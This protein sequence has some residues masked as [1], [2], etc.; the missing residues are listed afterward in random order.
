MSVLA[1]LALVAAPRFED[2]TAASG[3]PAVIGASPASIF[4]GS[5]AWV[6][7]DGDPFPDLLLG[8]PAGPTRLY[9]NSG[10]LPFREATPAALTALPN[11]SCIT[12]FQWNDGPLG[13]RRALALVQSRS[14][15]ALGADP[16]AFESGG[17]FIVPFPGGSE[18]A[19]G[20]PATSAELLT[21]G[22]LDGDGATD[23]FVA[24]AGCGTGT[25]AVRTLFRLERGALGYRLSPEDAVAS[26]GCNPVPMVTDFDGEGRPALLVATD[27]GS[28]E[29][30][31]FLYRAG[32]GAEALPGIYG[33]GVAAAD[34]DGDAAL[35]YVLS[36]IGPDLVIRSGNGARSFGALGRATEWGEVGRR[37]KWGIAFL[38][39]DNDGDEELW[40]TAGLPGLATG[41]PD[42]VDDD[43]HLFVPEPN[44][45][46]TL[47]VD[48][49]DQADAAGLLELTAKRAV[50]VADFD[51]DGRLDALVTGLDARSLYR[52]VTEAAGRWVAFRAPELPG[53]NFRLEACGRVQYREL[54]GQQAVAAHERVVHFGLGDCAG[55]V[56]LTVR[57][58]WLGQDA[59]RTFDAVDQ[60]FALEHPGAV[61]F[62]PPET[63]PGATVRVYSTL[64]GETVVGGVGAGAS[65]ADF[66]APS[67]AGAH[68]FLVVSAGHTLALQPKLTVRERVDVLLTDPHPVR[69]GARFRV[70]AGD[71]STELQTAGAAPVRV[72][73]GGV[74]QEVPS[75]ANFGGDSRA[76]VSPGIK[77][78]STVR[79]APLDA[80]GAASAD[81]EGRLSV[82]VGDAVAPLEPGVAPWRVA[83]LLAFDEVASVQHG[84]QT[85][86]EVQH[87]GRPG[88]A[89]PSRSR[90]WVVTPIARADGQD[91][92]DVV[93]IW[94]DADGQLVEPST[95]EL[96][97]APGCTLVSAAWTRLDIGFDLVGWSARLRAGTAPGAF[98]VTAGGLTGVV[99]LMPREPAAPTALST[100]ERTPTGLRLIPRDAFGQR[101]GSGVETVPPF[102]YS[103][104]GA[105]RRATL[106]GPLQLGDLVGT[107][108]GDTMHWTRLDSA[109][110]TTCT[111]RGRG[112]TGALWLL[113]GAVGLLLRRRR[114]GPRAVLALAV[115]GCAGEAP[116]PQRS[117]EVRSGALNA[118]CTAEVIGKGVKQV[119]GDYL[120][121]VIQCE[122]GSAPLEALKAQ[123]VAARSYLYYKLNTSGSI[124][125]GQSDQVYSCG[126]TPSATHHQA[127][128]ETAG[129]VLRYSNTQVAAF[130]VA[131]AVPSTG[132][133]VAAPGDND[134][135]NT[136]K[137]VTYNW[138][139]SGSGLEQ[140]TLG[141]V[142]AGNY[143]NRGCKSQNGASC[144]AKAGWGYQDILRFYYG[145][146]IGI[147]TAT[148]SCV[149]ACE[150]SGGAT[151]STPCGNCGNMTRT[152]DGCQWGAWSGCQG[153]GPCA[154]GASE[155][156]GCGS[157]GSQT[158]SCTGE[159]NWGEFGACSD[160]G[161]CAPGATETEACGWCG[162]RTRSCDGG[163]G[164][165]P[166]G[167]CGG[168]G[169]C[170]AGAVEHQ[171]CA[172]CGVE[173]RS[174]SDQCTWS[175]YGS[176]T[177]VDPNDGGAPVACMTDAPGACGTGVLMCLSGEVACV[178]TGEAGDETCNDIDD[179]CDG[180]TDE[181]GA[182]LGATLPPRA[183]EFVELD[184]PL[185]ASPG[186]ALSATLRFRNAGSELW[187]PG[188]VGLHAEDVESLGN[189][190]VW[191][192]SWESEAVVLHN[193]TA[194][195]P[196]EE[197]V[198]RFD[199]TAPSFPA[200]TRF[201]LVHTSGLIRCPSAEATWE[202]S[203]DGAPAPS[204]DTASSGAPDAGG[205]TD[206]GA[207]GAAHGADTHS[208]GRPN[209]PPR[210]RSGCAALGQPLEHAGVVWTLAPLLLFALRR[211]RG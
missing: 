96:P 101:I 3:V 49:Q 125:D 64:P 121:H 117:L 180:E 9:L 19:I 155:T 132:D 71:A 37:F 118:Y 67:S 113:L 109:D 149:Q 5:A 83:R 195:A 14:P 39:A 192:S 197:L 33:M 193:A 82:V 200:A 29:T 24:S 56:T 99:W 123:A 178:A 79:F 105:Y 98:T 97:Q 46:D 77:G 8:E 34:L 61:W 100:M 52:N 23:L 130:Y 95:A 163:C 10:T 94:R 55:P 204:S 182:P 89:E 189:A 69:V 70:V 135:S 139:K 18:L 191:H 120:A 196:G 53:T 93:L 20:R 136:E 134:Y 36:S 47:L 84:E 156:A 168:A 148:G 144:L 171:P 65:G 206:T 27:Y 85:L 184:A 104:N 73:V 211:R 142:N 76:D 209:T 173:T 15:G 122:N 87:L 145:M 17:L 133:C 103:G 26:T 90:L 45:R 147:V 58:P 199:A 110:D 177:S 202:L 152:C 207:D 88:A 107:L 146:D 185:D 143:A 158:R 31:S 190:R 22:D 194:V 205:S 21:A 128:S 42:V 198:L 172:S 169:E 12:P 25:A 183:A 7:W 78:A 154:P 2:V 66:V 41:V 106:D 150:C 157:C 153:E 50:V 28:L 116:E 111:A 140:T 75:V 188:A 201:R 131:G 141:W 162:T 63:S 1:V 119:E 60:L 203:I 57:W 81:V 129:V 176:C 74:A 30:P 11:L 160:G 112:G 32:R 6:D 4:G 167:E 40:L 102:E 127:V 108:E 137:Y 115:A 48:G 38:D 187:E 165:E 35:D 80:F 13:P 210:D 16:T 181:G 59:P 126:K 91:L 54:S 164:W 138:G 44:A 72:M 43:L 114:A 179:D 166:F 92:V 62:D 170:A 186:A 175:S 68:R 51:R 159:C 174:C 151:E 161:A 208:S 124:A 86:V